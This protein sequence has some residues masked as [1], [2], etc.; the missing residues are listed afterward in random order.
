MSVSDK[1][2]TCST[3]EGG[4]SNWGCTVFCFASDHACV[5]ATVAATKDRFSYEFHHRV[6]WTRVELFSWQLPPPA[7]CEAVVVVVVN[8]YY[9]YYY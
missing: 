5:F 4:A 1:L 6:E 2:E 8:C 7:L 3:L 9:C